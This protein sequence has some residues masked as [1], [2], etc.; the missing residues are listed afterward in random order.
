MPQPE[1]E[2]VVALLVS[3][4]EYPHHINQVAS[5]GTQS[6]RMLR[7]KLSFSQPYAIEPV[8]IAQCVKVEHVARLSPVR[9]AAG[10]LLVALLLG[11]FYYLGVYWSQLEPGTTIRVGLLGLAFLYGLKWA[12]MSRHHRIAFC[13]QD[14]SRLKW[15]SRSGDFKYKERAVANV[16]QYFKSLG[17]PVSSK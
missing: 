3:T 7:R 4:D 9:I 5:V 1:E 13:L 17:I 8:A 12:F 14:G 16:L 11:I 2:E 15:R 10:V 6:I